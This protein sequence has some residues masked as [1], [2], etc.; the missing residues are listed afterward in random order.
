MSRGAQPYGEFANLNEVAERIKSGYTMQCPRGCRAEVYE[1][2][3]LPCWRPQENTRPGFSS[4]CK[5]LEALGATPHEPAGERS[6]SVGNVM[7]TP[8]DHANERASDADWLADLD[9]RDLLGPTV[10]FLAAVFAPKVVMAVQ[11][12]WRTAKRGKEVVPPE[13]AS[14]SVAM[15]SVGYTDTHKVMCPRDGQRGCAYVDILAGRDDV[16]RA[17]AL[18]SCASTPVSLKCPVRRAHMR[19]FTAGQ[20]ARMLACVALQLLRSNSVAAEH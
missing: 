7:V 14:I 1:E 11:P 13:S 10:H 9:D 4:L 5:T 18:L 2:V 16:G 17:V 15:E 6:L 8:A 19:V 3:M 20:I 12:P